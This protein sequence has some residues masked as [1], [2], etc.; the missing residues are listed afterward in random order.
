MEVAGY[1]SERKK[2]RP[3]TACDALCAMLKES[4]PNIYTALTILATMPVSTA[5]AE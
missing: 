4:C 3:R 1:T 5:T 2:E